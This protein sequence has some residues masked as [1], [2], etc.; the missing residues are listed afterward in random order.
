MG[1][2]TTNK[3]KYLLIDYNVL[4]PLSITGGVQISE[5]PEYIIGLGWEF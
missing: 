4:G 3:D 5:Q 1:V 2:V